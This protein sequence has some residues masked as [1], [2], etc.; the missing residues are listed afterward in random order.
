MWLDW[1]AD[2]QKLAEN[3]PAKTEELL[4]LFQTALT[5]YRYC[6]VSK[7]LLKMVIER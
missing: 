5:D 6:K 4:A 7:K 1:L 3:T 2:E